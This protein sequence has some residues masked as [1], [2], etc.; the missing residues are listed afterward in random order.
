MKFAKNVK[1]FE[2]FASE[3]MVLPDPLE[4]V[5]DDNQNWEFRHP[6]MKDTNVRGKEKKDKL[7]LCKLAYLHERNK[8]IS[9]FKVCKMLRDLIK[10]ELFRPKFNL[11]FIAAICTIREA[12]MFSLIAINSLKNEYNHYSCDGFS[13]WIKTAEVNKVLSTFEKDYESQVVYLDH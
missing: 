12:N 6:G 5:Q 13:E 9:L 4:L 11:L 8:M 3:L 2:N 7:E 10:I 1:N